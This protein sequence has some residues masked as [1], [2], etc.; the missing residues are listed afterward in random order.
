MVENQT[1]AYDIRKIICLQDY[2]NTPARFNSPNTITMQTMLIK[3]PTGP[4]LILEDGLN[5][6]VDSVLFA[7]CSSISP[8]GFIM[9]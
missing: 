7:N 6:K 2:Y 3:I 1:L 9:V 4:L 5:P 8:M